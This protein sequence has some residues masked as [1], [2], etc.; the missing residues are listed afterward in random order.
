VSDVDSY[1][2]KRGFSISSFASLRPHPD[3]SAP[4]V[5]SSAAKVSLDLVTPSCALLTPFRLCA[6]LQVFLWSISLFA[7]STIILLIVLEALQTQHEAFVPNLILQPQ[8][9]FSE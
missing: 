1:H 7:V 3:D 8:T 4:G 5:W 9:I 6:P 2:K